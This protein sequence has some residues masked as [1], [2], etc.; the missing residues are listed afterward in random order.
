MNTNYDVINSKKF[1]ELLNKNELTEIEQQKTQ[2]FEDLM[3]KA[4]KYS[5]YLTGSL[6]EN[7]DSYEKG[8]NQLAILET[9]E[10]NIKLTTYQQKAIEAYNKQKSNALELKENKL[11]SLEKNNEVSGGY[12]NS[13]VLIL[14]VL[15]TGILIGV[16]L[17]LMVK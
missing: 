17:F 2:K 14:S 7:K 1:F 10:P 13:F 8:I 11:R 12:T 9:T 5:D 4:D 6:K 3:N 16:V 15:A